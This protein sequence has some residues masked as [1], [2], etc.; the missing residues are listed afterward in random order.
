[1][2]ISYNCQQIGR[3]LNGF[4]FI[5]ILKQMSNPL[6]LHIIPVDKTGT[7]SPKNLFEWLVPFANQY[8][9]MIRHKTPCIK[10]ITAY[11]LESFQFPKIFLVVFFIFKNTLTINAT[12]NDM[13][14][15]SGTFYSCFP[16]HASSPNSIIQKRQRSVN[17]GDGSLCCAMIR[18]TQRTVPCVDLNCELISFFV[19]DLVYRFV[20]FLFVRLVHP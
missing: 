17:T 1:M 9:N 15:T 14:Y 16:R 4:A 11:F 20:D 2:Y 12:H 10:L 6:I 7:D 13:V 18:T 19:P 3:I 5:P 8:M